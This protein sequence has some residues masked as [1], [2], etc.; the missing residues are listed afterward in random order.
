[1]PKEH[2]RYANTIYSDELDDDGFRKYEG[3]TGVDLSVKWGNA[4][5]S[6]T[7][8]LTVPED[9]DVFLSLKFFGDSP[10]NPSDADYHEIQLS[11]REINTFIE[12]LRK[13]RNQAF[14]PDA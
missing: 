4:T 12:V 13:A 9:K 3:A 7:R 5:P 8:L 1:M 6:G 2:I 11:R 14:G 10:T